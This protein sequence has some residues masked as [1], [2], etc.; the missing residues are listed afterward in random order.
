MSAAIDSAIHD[1][2]PALVRIHVVSVLPREGREVKRESSGS[3]AIISADGYVITNH[4]VAG[5]AKRIQCTLSNKQEIEARLIGTDPLSDIAVI[6]LDL[7]E[8][9]MKAGLPF[10]RFGDSDRLRVGERVLAM[11]SPMA[12]SQ[13]VTQGIVSNVEMTFPSMLWPLT[14]KLDGEETGSLVRWIGHD[15]QISPGN[16]GGPLVN[17][18]GEIVGINEISFGL[19]GAIPGNLAREI[20]DQLIRFGDVARSFI[21]LEMQPLLKSQAAQ[22]GALIAGVVQGSPADKAGLRAGDL[23]LSYDGQ[24]VSISYAEQL[25][26]LNRLLFGTPVGKKVELRYLRDGREANAALVTIARGRAQADDVE[27]MAWGATACDLTLLSAKELNK[28]PYTGAL[29]ASLRQGGAAAEAKPPLMMQDIVYEVDGTPIKTLKDLMAVTA[30]RTAGQGAPVPTLVAFERRNERYLT[31]VHLGQRDERDRS[32]DATKAW[33]AVSTQVLTSDL[34][35]ALKLAGQKGVRVTFVYPGSQAEKSGL[36][37]GDIILKLDGE[38]IAASRPDE[39]EIFPAMVRQYRVGSQVKLDVV[40]GGQ[41]KTIE[42]ALEPSP[43]STRELDE[44]KDRHFEFQARDLTSQDRV[45]EELSPNQQGA[46]ITGVENGGWAAV[47]HLAVG[48]IVQAID[49]QAVSTV[50]NLA[51]HMK[52]VVAQRPSRVVFFVRRGVHTLFL[53]IEPTWN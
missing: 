29:I 13:S 40:R 16:S 30:K 12:L 14:F 25:P 19:S 43:P 35:K 9:Q 50:A 20:A 38:V 33:L 31:V 10:A 21:G 22:Q 15:A 46:L 6:K 44:Y 3:G 39:V 34:A 45:E 1:V 48:D 23:L 5:R 18:R 47:A 52:T 32:A 17:L 24:P 26:A 41:P 42:V 8:Q 11:G 53:E 51:S 37:M 49:G 27:L 4:H 2:Y 36:K 7:T 28:E